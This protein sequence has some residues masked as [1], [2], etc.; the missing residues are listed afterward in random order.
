MEYHYQGYCNMPP[1][2]RTLKSLARYA[3]RQEVLPGA[4]TTRYA[5]RYSQENASRVCL[6]PLDTYICGQISLHGK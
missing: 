1:V 3:G 5:E 2:P 6:V 4:G